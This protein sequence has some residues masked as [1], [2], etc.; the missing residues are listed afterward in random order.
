MSKD[1]G[2]FVTASDSFVAARFR[3]AFS[4]VRPKGVM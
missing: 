2:G 1:V 3:R 4:I